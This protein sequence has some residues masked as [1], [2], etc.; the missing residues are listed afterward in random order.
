MSKPDW[1]IHK[2]A[3]RAL[4]MVVDVLVRSDLSYPIKPAISRQINLSPLIPAIIKNLSFPAALS[5]P[6]PPR[7]HRSADEAEKQ[8]SRRALLP[9]IHPFECL[10]PPC[11]L[12]QALVFEIDKVWRREFVG[13][14]S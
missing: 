10:S 6:H 1:L 3:A 7:S 13:G 8:P 11:I 14:G 4:Q 5:H 9:H 12:K 2:T